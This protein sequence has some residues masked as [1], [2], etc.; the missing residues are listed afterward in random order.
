MLKSFLWCSLLMLL[1]SHTAKAD[2][3]LYASVVAA[4][5]RFFDA[6]NRC[7]IDVMAKMF[8]QDLEF[9]HDIGGVSDYDSTMA[10]TKANCDRKLGLERS[11]NIDSLR[12]FPIPGFGAIQVGEHE[13]CHLANGALDC[14][15]FGFTHVW[16][17]TENGWKIARV[18]S[19]GH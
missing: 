3:T 8:S 13:F 18:V 7:D 11:L 6:F 4:D 19:Y 2:D 17:N 9:Y 1:L 5:E 16:Q 12:V 10:S 14:G 15:T